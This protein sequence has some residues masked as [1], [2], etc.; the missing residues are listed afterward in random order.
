VVASL[1]AYVCFLNVIGLDIAT[2]LFALVVM[3]ICGE[4]RLFRLT[5]YPILWFPFLILKID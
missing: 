1:G 4:R 5:I 2:W 3:F